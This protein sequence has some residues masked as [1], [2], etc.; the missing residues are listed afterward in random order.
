LLVEVDV[1]DAIQVDV[2]L[3]LIETTYFVGDTVWSVLSTN[4]QDLA[5]LE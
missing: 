5:V 2:D 4:I 1:E 3:D